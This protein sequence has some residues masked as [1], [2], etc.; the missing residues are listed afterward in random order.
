MINLR[1]EKLY[2]RF[3]LYIIILKSLLLILGHAIQINKVPEAHLGDTYYTG[4]FL[5]DA[6]EGASN[7]QSIG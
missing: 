6:K 4:Q 5:A 1:T 3:K 7:W 2:S